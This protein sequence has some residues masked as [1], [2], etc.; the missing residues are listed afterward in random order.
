MNI[1]LN[2]EEIQQAI[3]DFLQRNYTSHIEVVAMSMKGSRSNEGYS[4][5]VDLALGSVN[6]HGNAP[7]TKTIKEIVRDNSLGENEDQQETK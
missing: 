5:E 2:Q 4:L 1:T 7:K 3:R 6:Y